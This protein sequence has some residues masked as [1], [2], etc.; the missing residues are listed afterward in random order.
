VAELAS[1]DWHPSETH[2]PLF[3]AGRLYQTPTRKSEQQR[4][5]QTSKIVRCVEMPRVSNNGMKLLFKVVFGV[6]GWK[7]SGIDNTEE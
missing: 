2:V 1:A 4:E 7:T 5:R 3:Q 6:N